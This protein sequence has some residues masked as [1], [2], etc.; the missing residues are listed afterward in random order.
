MKLLTE[1]LEQIFKEYPFGSQDSKGMEAKV[2]VK[3]FNPCGDC[4]IFEWEWG[5]VSLKELQEIQLPFG[6]MIERD[7]HMSSNIVRDNVS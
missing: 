3:Y 1:E 2:I 6:L 5:Y 4:H 7:L